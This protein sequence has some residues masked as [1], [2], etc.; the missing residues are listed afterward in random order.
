VYQVADSQVVLRAHKALLRRGRTALVSRNVVLLGLT[1]L[2]TDISSEMVTTILPLY[3]LYGLG[4]SPLAFG[5]VDGLQQGSSALVR[6]ASGFVADRLRRYKEI[7]AIGYGLSAVSKLGMLA[8]GSSLG[9]IGAV[10]F[11]DR[12][13]KGIRTGPRDAL[14]SLSTPREELGTAFGVH[15]TLDTAGALIGPLVAF[16]LLALAP[17]A[18][19]TVFVVSF[20]FALVGLGILVTF[21]QNRKADATEPEERPSLKAAAGLLRIPRLRLLLVVG[22]GLA[23]AT[24]SDGFVYLALQRRMDFDLR[25]LPLLFVGTAFTYMLLATPVGRLA[26]RAGRGRVFVGGYVL[27]LGVY[28]TLL[29]PAIGLPALLVVLLLFGGYYAATDGVLMALASTLLPEELRASGLSL[30]VSV[31]SVA[32]LVASI[33]FGAVWAAAGIHAAIVVFGIALAA[34]TALGATLLARGRTPADA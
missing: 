5:V 14:I 28:A 27:L 18:Y 21:V 15:R 29:L 3:L 13:G 31:T 12:T 8:A 22:A 10:I 16:G 4:L 11:V 30:V 24:M 2:F 32:R 19:D 9:A 34:T 25:F 26:D 23:V 17:R 1:S 33:A 7:A 20:A 6:V